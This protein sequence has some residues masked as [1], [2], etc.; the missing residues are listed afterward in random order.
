MRKSIYTEPADA[1]LK[2]VRDGGQKLSR[3]QLT[4]WHLFEV[5][6][7]PIQRPRATGRGTETVYPT[8]T[9]EQVRAA[10]PLIRQYGSFDQAKFELWLMGYDISQR[11]IVYHLREAALL[12]PPIPPSIE[13]GF[14]KEVK[15]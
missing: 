11:Y 10:I 3:A 8:A 15:E 9:I 2:A 13:D 6:P 7:R 5:I 14:R 4:R 12:V 1:V